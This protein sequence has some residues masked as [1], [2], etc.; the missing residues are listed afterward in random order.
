MYRIAICDDDVRMRRFLCRTVSESGISCRVEEFAGGADLLRGYG[1]YDI[2]F[3]DIDMPGE[4]ELKWRKG[5]EG[6][7]GR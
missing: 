4:M 5:F 1:E 3:L 6:R 2:L 7:T